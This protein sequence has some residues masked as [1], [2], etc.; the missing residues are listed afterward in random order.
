MSRI[1][2]AIT[3]S[4]FMVAILSPEYG[5]SENCTNELNYAINCNIPVVPVFVEA[6]FKPTGNVG[7]RTSKLFYLVLK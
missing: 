3:Q 4:E 5:K 1:A 2:N 6:G 7:L